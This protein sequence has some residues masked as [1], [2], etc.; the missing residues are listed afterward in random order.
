MGGL[1]RVGKVAKV[2]GQDGIVADLPHLSPPTRDL[3][4]NT[5]GKEENPTPAATDD[6]YAGV[7]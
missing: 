4:C 5:M 6:R 3:C 2:Q 1:C 7:L